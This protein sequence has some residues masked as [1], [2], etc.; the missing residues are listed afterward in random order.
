MNKRLAASVL[1]AALLLAGCGGTGNIQDNDNKDIINAEVSSEDT[2][3]FSENT[4]FT[5]RVYEP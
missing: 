3:E 5:L 4:M 1:S 2:P